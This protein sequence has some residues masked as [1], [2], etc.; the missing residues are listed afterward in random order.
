MIEGTINAKYEAVVDLRIQGPDGRSLEIE[1]VVDT[2]FS[3]FLTLPEGTVAELDLPL[4]GSGE[5]IL[6]NDTT[7]DFS[8]HRVAALWDGQPIGVDAYVT[9]SAPL[10]GM[11]LLDGYRLIVDVKV[12]GRVVIEAAP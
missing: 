8:V 3:G 2:G 6:A 12:G 5:A 11:L 7:V 9:G 10:I 4:V 1:A